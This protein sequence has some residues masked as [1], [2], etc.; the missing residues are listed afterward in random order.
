MWSYYVTLRVR[1]LREVQTMKAYIVERDA[2]VY[3]IQ[4]LV[5]YANGGPIWGVLKG[6]G[7]GLGVLPMANLLL[8]MKTLLQSQMTA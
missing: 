5:E 8:I 1:P 2:L 6:N 4:K 7:Y 3:N